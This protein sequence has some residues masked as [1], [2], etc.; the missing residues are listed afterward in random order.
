MKFASFRVR[1][2]PGYGLVTEEGAR[3]VGAVFAARY[4]DLKS[5]IAAGA[6][7]G[8]ADDARRNPRVP[9]ASAVELEPVIPEPGKILCVGVN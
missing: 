9:E 5:A 8:A 2:L 4:P 3:P 7:A 1:G 6:L